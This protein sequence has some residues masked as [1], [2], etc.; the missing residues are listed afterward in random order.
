MV[1]FIGISVNAEKVHPAIGG[2]PSG[3]EEVSAAVGEGSCYQEP[4]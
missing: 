4:K 1:E 3:L 2:L